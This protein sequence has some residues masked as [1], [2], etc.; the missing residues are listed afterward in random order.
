MIS[1]VSF[2]NFMIA[3]AILQ[4]SVNSFN[5][6]KNKPNLPVTPDAIE[7]GLKAATIDD[8][9][10]VEDVWASVTKMIHSKFDELGGE[11]TLTE[12]T[13][14]EIITTAVAGSVLGTMVGSPLVVGAALG[15]AGS[16]M[17]QTEN[18]EKA[19]EAFGQA[20]K[21]VL[22]QANSA[23]D[24]TKKELE[25]E[26]DL[27]KVSAKILLAIQEK[28]GELQEDIKGSPQRMMQ[29]LPGRMAEK[30]KDNVLHTVESDEFRS[31]PKRSLNSFM[32]FMESDQVKTFKTDAMKAIQDGQADA[33]KAIHDGL[34]SEEMKALQ[35][36]ASKAVQD[37][38]ESAST[39]I[40]KKA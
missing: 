12:E 13:K 10:D 21:E 37:K 9:N 7:G 20:G 3:M 2:R 18:G 23:I 38:I 17:L 35:S 14:D 33:M 31:I 6:V 28:A 36:R 25:N 24:F 22:K 19:K 27:S 16:H 40:T 5:P 8:A 29:E 39:K 26:K 32:V 34:E 4:S 15:Y 11:E 1:T 30:L